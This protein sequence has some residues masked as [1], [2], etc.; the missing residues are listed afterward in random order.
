MKLPRRNFLHLAAAAAA[1]PAMSRIAWAQAYPTRPVRIIVT[2]AAGSANDVN[3]RLIAQWLSERLGQPF[4]VDSRPG[5]GGNVGAT[6][7]IRS[8]ADGY[9]LFLISISQAINDSFY[10]NL[11]YRIVRD[12]TPVASLF[13]ASYVMRV[14]P[15]LPAKTDPQFIKSMTGIDMVHVP[16]RS[17]ALA[18]A[19]VISG[20][21]HV[22]F[23][24]STDSVPLIRSGQVR[25]LAVCSAMRSAAL[26]EVPTMAESVPPVKTRIE[27][28][29]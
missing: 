14:N 7:A 6:E 12:I 17:S 26:P 21:M 23:T 19:D 15:S 10:S 5:S 24:T 28:L 29:T 27:L 9:T 11:P 1:L 8:P 13:R 4:I 22:Q 16:Y 25:A 3:G 2:F 18:L 20:Q